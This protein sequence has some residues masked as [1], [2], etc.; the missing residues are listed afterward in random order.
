MLVIDHNIPQKFRK[1]SWSAFRYGSAGDDVKRSNNCS[2]N[3]LQQRQIPPMRTDRQ[4]APRKPQ[5]E[6]QHTIEEE[7]V[8]TRVLLISAGEVTD[9]AVRI[10]RCRHEEV[11]SL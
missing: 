3:P 5:Q 10:L 7:E 2:G 8:C 4:N 9:D 11:H 1:S 6:Q